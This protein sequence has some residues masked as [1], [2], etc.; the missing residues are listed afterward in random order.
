M[1][2]EDEARQIGAFGVSLDPARFQFF[3]EA[4]E[5]GVFADEARTAT[6]LVDDAC[7]FLNRPGFAGG[8]GCALH[9]GALDD[10]ERPMDWKPAVCWQVP[11][12]IEELGP[13]RRRLRRWAKSDWGPA[14]TA[15]CC[16]DRVHERRGL[17]SAFVGTESVAVSL[18]EELEALTGP[19][20]AVEIQRRVQTAPEID[21]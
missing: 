3:A 12:R 17:A 21:R 2:D 18:G 15:W 6:R 11:F 8:E 7:I 5:G 13:G 1:L 14:S 4:A 10:G 19:E 16:T 9:L 20:V